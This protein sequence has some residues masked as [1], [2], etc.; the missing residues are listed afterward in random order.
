MAEELRQ[1]ARDYLEGQAEETTAKLKEMGVTDDLLNFEPLSMDILK[2]LA[3]KGIKTL[4]DLADLAAD[5][6]AEMAPKSGMDEDQINE[7]IMQA[8]AHWFEDEKDSNEAS[9]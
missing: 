2:I 4:D 9:A 8:R 7:L 3:P 6:F 1:R 5:E